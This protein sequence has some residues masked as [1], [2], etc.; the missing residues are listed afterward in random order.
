MSKTLKYTS[1]DLPNDGA[2]VF[3]CRKSTDES[4]EE[5]KQSIPDQI[6]HCLEYTKREW[7][8][9]SKK[10]ENFQDFESPADIAKEELEPDISAR[11][12]YKETRDL[13]IVK[14]QKTAKEP[15]ARE[16]WNALIKLVKKG[17]IKTIISYS[18][19]RQARNMLE[20]GEL[21]SLVD[22]WQLNLRYTNFHFENTASG[23]MMLGIWFVFSKQYSDKLSEDISRWNKTSVAS[24]KSMWRHKH[25]YRINEQGYHEPHP[26]YFKIFQE[27]FKKKL[28]GETD[29]NIKTFL[30]ASG[31]VRDW[32]KKWRASSEISEKNLYKIWTDPFY[33]WLYTH[34]DSVSDL[35][36]SNTLYE[37][38][39]SEE[40]HQ[41]L[42]TRKIWNYSRTHKGIQSSSYE[43]LRIVENWFIKTEDGSSLSFNLPN[44]KR[45]EEKRKS[46]GV[47][48]SISDVVMPSQ[49]LYTCKNKT[50]KFLNYSV[51]WEDINQKMEELLGTL[52]VTDADY[53]K[54]E[55]F[56]VSKL[57]VLT[58]NSKRKRKEI[59]LQISRIETE[60]SDYI[61]TNMGISKD[62]EEQKIYDEQKKAFDTKKAI[63]EQKKQDVSTKENHEI[64]ELEAFIGVLKDS[65]KY[66]RDSSNVRK[67]KVIKL[68]CSNM[69]LDEKKKLHITVKPWLEKLFRNWSR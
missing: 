27:A 46:R 32:T 64:L 59:D 30:D 42:V 38:I 44:K 1:V 49:V 7:I 20:G 8:L 58:E 31:Y 17:K 19:D 55:N 57:T 6:K 45:F 36:E 13:F 12:L 10:P 3:Y 51:T 5:Q 52:K 63:L 39:I 37:P 48:V 23:K 28:K 21:I 22:K 56:C 40:E 65:K 4:S 67:R 29:K 53:N 2:I 9:V 33:Y 14:E 15:W 41:V 68:L 69:I 54:Y 24:W 43:A 35:R 18:P 62:A 66:Y 61:R 50:S 34:G 25:G 60:K 47:E 11:K 16:K 26:T